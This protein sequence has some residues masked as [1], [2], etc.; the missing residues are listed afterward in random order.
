MSNK[1]QGEP[2]FCVATTTYNMADT[3]GR[4]YQSVLNQTYRNFYWLIIDNGSTDNTERI[5]S[6]MQSEGK[7]KIEYIKKEHGIRATGIN[8]MLDHITGDLCVEIHADDMLK[9]DAL[10]IFAD[11]WNLIPERKRK[12]IWTMVAHCEDGRKHEIVGKKFPEGI[13]K[14]EKRAWRYQYHTVG[15][16]HYAMNVHIVKTKRINTDVPE[17]VNYLGE[18]LLW[19]E[20]QREY[21]MWFINKVT[22]QYYDD[23]PNRYSVKKSRDVSMAT[24]YA[25][26][27]SHLQMLN[28][29]FRFDKK[30]F[31]EFLK[32]CGIAFYN[33]MLYGISCR[34][35]LSDLNN[36]GGKAMLILSWPL[37]LIRK[38]KKVRG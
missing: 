3:I 12:Y 17:K 14:N 10:K 31:V 22:R 25:T 24:R 20:Y 30:P 23:S 37:L 34:E 11:E 19:I 27:F 35:I 9:K 21:L 15:E 32:H 5:I 38:K 2:Y 13:N 29:T 8:C 4:T 7:I 33:G 1:M 6:E 16:K 28:T 36:M 18:T 26:Y